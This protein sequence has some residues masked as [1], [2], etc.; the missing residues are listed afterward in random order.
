MME[1]GLE[2][3]SNKSIIPAGLRAESMN[4]NDIHNIS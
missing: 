1:Q 2:M 3:I 4:N